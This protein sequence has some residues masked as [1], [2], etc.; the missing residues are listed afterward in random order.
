MDESAPSWMALRARFGNGGAGFAFVIPVYNHARNVGQ[1]VQAAMD[2]GAPVVVVDDGSTDGSG[3]AAARIA[4]A[5]VLRHEKNLGKGAAILTGLATVAAPSI[6][7][8][9]AVTVDADGQH[10]PDDARGLLAGALARG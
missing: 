10:S 2:S 8:R 3:D 5:T 7:A 1:V 6:G 9:F 4:G